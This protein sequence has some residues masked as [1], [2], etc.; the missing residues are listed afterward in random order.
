MGSVRKVPDWDTYFMSLVQ[1]V[2]TRSKDPNTQCGAV[3]V[4]PNNEIRTTGYNSMPFGIEDRSERFERP[5]KYRWVEHGERNAIYLAARSGVSLAGCRLYQFGLPCID[6]A[7]GI[8]QV[9]IA[10]VIIDQSA[11][12]AW[13]KTG[14]RYNDD[15]RFVERMLEE[16][17]V[18][19]RPW[20]DTAERIAA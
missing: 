20:R 4:G 16:A 12:E 6:C 14:T 9:G 8:I 1:T 2:K 19:L 18:K 5:E 11:Q 7:R 13:E 15:F 17:R 10:E 3:I